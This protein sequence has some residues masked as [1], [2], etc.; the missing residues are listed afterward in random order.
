MALANELNPVPSAP[1]AGGR[2]AWLRL[3]HSHTAFSATLL[4][5]G[6]TLLSGVLGLVRQKYI[7]WIFG[8]GPATDAYNAAFNLPD[9]LSYFMVGGVASITLITVLN[10]YRQAG[11]EE[12][13]DRALS[14]VLNA[15]T[16]M[17]TAA[18][19]LAEIF[20]PLYTRAF[21][22]HFTPEGAALCTR[23][24]R[25]MLPQPL[26]FFIGGVLGSRLLVR[27]IFLYQAVTPLIYNLGI[28]LGAVFLAKYFGIYSLAI[29][30]LAGVIVGPA[31]FTAYGAWRSG[32]RYQ[33]IFD[34]RHPA[35]LEWLR[36]TFPLMV[37][38]SLTYAD[39]WIASYYASSVAG[40]ISRLTVAKSLFNSPMTIIGSA[41]GA[42]SL[43]FFS[44]LFAQG[45]M[46]EFAGAVN[47]S[48][49]RVVATA[50]LAGAW[51]VA[52]SFPIIDLFRGGSFKLEDA[53]ETSE[54][55][56]IFAVSIA[57][58]SAQAIY[59]RSFYAAGN[60]MTPAIAGWAVTLVSIPIYAL[61]FHGMGVAGLA[62]ASDVGMVLSVVTLAVLLHRQRLVHIQ[63]LEYGELGGALAAA[64]VSY[65]GTSIC[66]RSL[67]L[68]RGYR[69]DLIA[70]AVGTVVWAALSGGVLL[71]TGSKLPAQLLRRRG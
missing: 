24:T 55:F 23:M 41:A 39:K 18:I 19:V 32:L 57:V 71:G 25:I 6:S 48:V 50:L 30:V 58:W 33:P 42:A 11:D 43:P 34:L 37:G 4:I 5:M 66:V 10:R 35:F 67:H 64:L 61:F 17:L 56:T 46:A 3:S 60:T 13:A 27:K 16:V 70:I 14:I 28:I 31:A 12:G 49:S 2:W 63:G 54:Y 47:R 62:V 8:A 1:Q 15:M 9:M 7:N 20:A 65:I 53:V 38:V 29:G 26:F 22:P 44:S 52:L 69:G 51:M 21:F 36:L 40:G 45:K 59:S 68:G